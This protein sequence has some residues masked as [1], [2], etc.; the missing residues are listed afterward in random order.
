MQTVYTYSIPSVTHS[1]ITLLLT[2]KVGSLSDDISKADTIGSTKDTGLDQRLFHG[3]AECYQKGDLSPIHVKVG[4][5]GKC[6]MDAFQHLTELIEH[7][8][9]QVWQRYDWFPITH[10]LV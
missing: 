10:Y 7:Q 1:V 4:Q 2:G 8:S 6:V 9:G 3:A 5:V